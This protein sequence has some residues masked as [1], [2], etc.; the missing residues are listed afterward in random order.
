[1]SKMNGEKSFGNL[2]LIQS[3]IFSA[4]RMEITRIA[5]AAGLA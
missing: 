3:L 1:M 5:L 2:L 4:N